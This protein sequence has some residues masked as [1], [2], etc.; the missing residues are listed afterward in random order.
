VLQTVGDGAVRKVRIVLL[1][2]EPFFLSGG[3]N[4]PILHERSS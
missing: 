3:H 2:R 4:A 1:A